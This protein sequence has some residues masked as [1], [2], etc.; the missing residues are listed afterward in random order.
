VISYLISR[1]NVKDSPV[2]EDKGQEDSFKAE[3]I[4]DHKFEDDKINYFVKWKAYPM[5]DCS[6]G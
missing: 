2:M 4:L 1:L 5:E 3:E 6:W